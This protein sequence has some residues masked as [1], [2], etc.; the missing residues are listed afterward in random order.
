MT[1]PFTASTARQNFSDIL[2]RAAY[3]GERV[4]VHR[5]KKPVAAVVPIEDLE[6]L[7]K[8]E[9]EVDLK[10]AREALKD[11]RTIPWETIKKK[12]RL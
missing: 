4:V 5:G 7:E 9:D 10:A 11:P 6:W 2:N 12:Y 3:R 1:K 8:I